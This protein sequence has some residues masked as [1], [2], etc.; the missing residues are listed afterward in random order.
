[1]RPQLFCLLS[2]LVLT[3]VAGAVGTTVVQAPLSGEAATLG[4]PVRGAEVFREQCRACHRAE[5]LARHLYPGGDDGSHGDVCN[6]LQTHGLTSAA[7]DCHIVAYMKEL[8][9]QPR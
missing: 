2:C 8:A 3:S 7:D 4:D 1:M 6:F 9:R 5:T